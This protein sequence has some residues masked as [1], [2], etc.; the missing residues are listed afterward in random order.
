MIE[1]VPIISIHALREEG[2][3]TAGTRP[4]RARISIHALREE[5]DSA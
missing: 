4:A 5:G 1:R 2:D 3:A